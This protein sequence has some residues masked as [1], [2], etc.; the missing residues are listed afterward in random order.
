MIK[1]FSISNFRGI[2]SLRME[3][4][5]QF[6]VIVGN[7]NCG[8][9]SI[10]DALMLFYSPS[11]PSNDILINRVRNY[12]K[13]DAES[14]KLLFYNLDTNSTISMKGDTSDGSREVAINYAEEN[15]G[16]VQ[17]TNGLSSMA[18]KL[19]G[20]DHLVTITHRDQASVFHFAFRPQDKNSAAVGIGLGE[21]YEETVTC[22]Y[23]TPNLNYS[24]T[25]DV[26]EQILKN[27][28]EQ[29]VLDVLCKIEPSIK[30]IILVGD[31]LLVDIGLSERIPIQMLGDGIRK[32]F[33]L[34]A[35]VYYCRN[36]VLLIDEVDNGIYYKSMPALWKAIIH[37]AM[38]HHV[39]IFVTTHNG[40]SLRVLSEVLKEEETDAQS[41]LSVFTL[42]KKE[43]GK[44]LSVRSNLQQLYFLTHQGIELR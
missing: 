2:R 12:M 43:E 13:S 3:G 6:N 38:L 27:K 36:G 20:L 18:E 33:Y 15:K 19:S 28:E 26:V 11:K 39:Q 42:R 22:Y 29:F 14:L 34:I 10:L 31:E 1:N 24:V 23:S 21:H 44:L 32:I 8:K 41:L 25:S 7:N 9:S 4:L 30:D 37:A 17:Y 35:L 16:T 40:E 5:S